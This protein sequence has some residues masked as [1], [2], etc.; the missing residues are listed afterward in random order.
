MLSEGTDAVIATRL[1][2]DQ[3]SALDRLEP[4]TRGQGIRGWRNRPSTGHSIAVVSAGTSDLPVAD[5]C[6][7]TL[8][9]LGHEP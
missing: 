9:A 4:H 3:A 7:L 6:R 8:A 1:T 5:E 2:P